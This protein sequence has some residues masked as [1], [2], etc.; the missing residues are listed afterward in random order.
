MAAAA[1]QADQVRQVMRTN[2][3]VGICGIGRIGPAAGAGS[4]AAPAVGRGCET[5]FVARCGAC[6]RF[7]L[8]MYASSLCCRS[9]CH[10]H[11]RS[12][13]STVPKHCVNMHNIDCC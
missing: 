1:M 8:S 3:P 2:G 12:V 9:A 4:A 13:P 5:A 10:A 11:G 6:L 7:S